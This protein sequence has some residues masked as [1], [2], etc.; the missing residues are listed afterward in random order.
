MNVL[1][2]D[3]FYHN[4]IF[5]LSWKDLYNLKGVC[6]EY[7]NTIPKCI[8]LITS[9]NIKK[10]LHKM[11]GNN[12]KILKNASITTDIPMRH[13]K[14]VIVIVRDAYDNDIDDN[15]IITIHK[16]GT[17]NLFLKSFMYNFAYDKI[18]F[19]NNDRNCVLEFIFLPSGIEDETINHLKYIIYICDDSKLYKSFWIDND[20]GLFT[21][22]DWL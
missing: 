3:P 12:Y 6:K 9:R 20:D 11:L 7:Q 13:D 1:F 10:K 8:K 17:H 18:T 14:H 16:S 4:I 21:V 15:S 19:R 5:Y 2:G 22:M